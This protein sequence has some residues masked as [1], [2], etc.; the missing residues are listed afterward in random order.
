M[1][2]GV[3]LGVGAAGYGALHDLT[4]GVIDRDALVA[5]GHDREPRLPAGGAVEFRLLGLGVGLRL[6]LGILGM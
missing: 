4:V 6:G 2:G 3:S 5:Q 1:P